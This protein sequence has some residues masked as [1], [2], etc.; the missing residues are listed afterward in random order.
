MFANN[1]FDL[2]NF[3]KTF[4]F[5]T[6][7]IKHF[8][9]KM[10]TRS[11]NFLFFIKIW[12]VNISL[13][14][15]WIKF[16]VWFLQVFILLFWNKIILKFLNTLQTLIFQI[17]IKLIFYFFKFICLF[18]FRVFYCINFFLFDVLVIIFFIL[19]VIS[20]PKL[21]THSVNIIFFDETSILLILRLILCLFCKIINNL[22]RVNKNY[23]NLRTFIA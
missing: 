20:L 15:F 4:N 3:R 13:N 8:P 11:T 21:M 1:I 9:Q 2:L 14:L 17:L 12:L 18:Y 10:N 22:T 23:I 7:Q 5:V 16:S 6:N 19:L